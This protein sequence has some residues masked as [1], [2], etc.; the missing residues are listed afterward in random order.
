MG[1]AMGKEEKKARIDK[2][3]QKVKHSAANRAGENL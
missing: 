2:N 1:C 3:E